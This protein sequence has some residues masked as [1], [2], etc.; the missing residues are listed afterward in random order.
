[1]EIKVEIGEE[2]TAEKT[3]IEECREAVAMDTIKQ[4]KEKQK[5]VLLNNPLLIY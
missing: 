2:G 4:P 3:R 5:M 1:L